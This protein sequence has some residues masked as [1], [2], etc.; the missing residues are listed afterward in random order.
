MPDA[1]LFPYLGAAIELIAL[2]FV[3]TG[4]SFALSGLIADIRRERRHRQLLAQRRD[5]V[6]AMQGSL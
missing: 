3:F 6:S 2:M 5:R 4:A 1:Q